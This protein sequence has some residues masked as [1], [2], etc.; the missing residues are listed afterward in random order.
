LLADVG[1]IRAVAV[2][3][4]AQEGDARM[5]AGVAAGPLV[6]GP[7]SRGGLH[8]LLGEPL[9]FDPSSEVWS[10]ATGLSL[11]TSMEP[12]ARLGAGLT[13]LRG[14]IGVFGYEDADGRTGALRVGSSP[15]GLRTAAAA[16]PAPESVAA[17]GRE[18]PSRP[19]PLT[20][21][22]LATLSEAAGRP[23]GD[24]WYPDEP[25]FPGGTLVHGGTRIGVVRE[26]VEPRRPALRVDVAVLASAGRFTRAGGAVSAR[27]ALRVAGFT[28][29]LAGGLEHPSYRNA[30]GER[31]SQRRRLVTVLS[32]EGA[33]PAAWLEA[34]VAGE[35]RG[36]DP[37]A[38]V[39]AQPPRE[40]G[41]GAE[42]ALGLDRGPRLEAHSEHGWLRDADGERLRQ[43][44][45]GLGLGWRGELAALSMDAE[46]SW[47]VPEYEDALRLEWRLGGAGAPLG[48]RLEHWV[49]LTWPEGAGGSPP[50][51]L[52]GAAGI[53]MRPGRFTLSLRAEADGSFELSADG[54]RDLESSPWEH[55]TVRIEGRVRVSVP[56]LDAEDESGYLEVY[57]KPDNVD[58]GSHER[59]GHDGGVEA[60]A[61]NEEGGDDPDNR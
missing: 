57:G 58:D 9:D 61:V 50:P 32:F 59:A 44:T 38:A 8:R 31:P 46:R 29:M 23:A 4:R 36:E 17:P 60:E 18:P 13:L 30:A 6:F 11:D 26:P 45:A 14:R 3:A 28:A 5:A 53:G 51:R 12:T 24:A 41:L 16:A 10:E 33:G 52:E 40:H 42:L 1:S 2:D 27:A 22:A 15:L 47:E 21:E 34:E 56:D 20:V 54:R 49:R 37:P 48:L 39:D 43:A 7:V 35:M 55:I 19:L 25:G